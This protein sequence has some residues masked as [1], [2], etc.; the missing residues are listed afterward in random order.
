MFVKSKDP[1]NSHTKRE[2]NIKLV[3]EFQR[4][5]SN[6][7]ENLPKK[8]V[9]EYS[10]INI[11]EIR[12]ILRRCEYKRITEEEAFLTNELRK[13]NE[14]IKQIEVGISGINPDDSMISPVNQA[15]DFEDQLTRIGAQLTNELTRNSPNILKGIVTS[16]MHNA[17]SRLKVDMKLD[18]SKKREIKDVLVELLNKSEFLFIGQTH[19]VFDAKVVLDN[20]ELLKENGLTCIALEIPISEQEGL[21]YYI[22]T[23]DISRLTMPVDKRVESI[24]YKLVIQRAK[25]LGLEI[26]A[27][28][29]TNALSLKLSLES[30]EKRELNM[31]KNLDR[32]PLKGKK[33]VFTGGFHAAT[34]QIP[35]NSAKLIL[36]RLHRSVSA[37]SLESFS[38]IVSSSFFFNISED[39]AVKMYTAYALIAN[40]HKDWLQGESF[41]YPTSYLSHLMSETVPYKDSYDYVFILNEMDSE[42]DTVQW[43]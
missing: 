3:H 33:L 19:R 7:I 18:P 21:N 12:L 20:L 13:M 30:L 5:V 35:F 43:V 17:V 42:I 41:A 15:G 22:L 29:D 8:K 38:S 23:G 10:S 39:T 6:A 28:D 25:E 16:V 2:N 4:I 11:Q 14:F 24:D 31:A 37:V 34:C 26:I 32:L 36:N 9:G 27:F 40:N 1:C